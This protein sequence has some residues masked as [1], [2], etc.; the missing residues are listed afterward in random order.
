M[1]THSPFAATS[2]SVSRIGLGC[3]GMSGVYGTADDESSIRTIHHALSLGLNFID[4]A[5]V[6][7]AGHNELLVGKALQ[8]RRDEVF[9]AT[10]FG[11]SGISNSPGQLTVNGSPDYL[12]QA[13]DRSLQRL[14]V[15]TIDLYYLHRLD[16]ATPIEETV[17]AMAELV[18][19]GKV[20][21]LGLSEVSAATLRRAHAV[22]PI[23]ALQ[24]EYSLWW[25]A[26][27]KDILPTCRELGITFVPYAPLGRGMLTGTL[28]S[29]DQLDEKDWRRVGPRFLGDAF[30]KNLA[31]V[32]AVSAI[33]AE[34]GVTPSQIALA[35]LLAQGLDLFPIPGTKRISYLEENWNSLSITLTPEEKFQLR[36]IADTTVIE[37]DRYPA[38]AGRLVDA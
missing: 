16:P 20:R 1:T 23:A 18:A 38:H 31:L 15:E 3:M 36:Q 10:K 28:T 14:G 19:A 17:G 12:R 22:H 32:H 25:T 4:T 29:P 7:G 26:P 37:G 13:C 9:L 33:A 8:G 24:S 35:W 6:Y 34:K 11:L 2:T 5:D 27:E 21:H 30:S